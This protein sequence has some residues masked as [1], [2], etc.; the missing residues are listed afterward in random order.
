MSIQWYP[1]HMTKAR[2][3]LAAA[4]PSQDVIIEVL[5]ARLPRASENPVVA[6]LRRQKPCLKVL[7]KSDLAD[8][9]I[10]EDWLRHFASG[11]VG[12]GGAVLA[13]ALRSD[14]AAEART[15]VLELSKRLCPREAT[16]A[17]PMRAMIV[18]V[19]N[20]GKS[21]LINTLM[22]RAV[23][24]VGDKPAVT[25]A[26]QQVVLK[27]GMVLFDSPGIMWPKI[28]DEAAALRLALAGSI[29][30]TAIEHAS[31]AAFGARFFL[32][33]YPDRLRACFKLAEMPPEPEELIAAIGRRRG[34]LR[35]GGAVDLHKA[36][37]ILIHAFRSGGLGRISLESP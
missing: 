24:A 25:K 36:S 15:R 27:S 2:R 10:T 6:E 19:P 32:E 29:P 8:P 7:S 30:D 20:V 5:D 4:M 18:G 3:E 1:G 28:E 12:E 13:V 9:Q 31:V 33:R 37:E 35:S 16:S 11:R 26:Q 34:C 17:Q 14:R 23:A 22:S 21:T